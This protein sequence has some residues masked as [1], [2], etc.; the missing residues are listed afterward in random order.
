MNE[1]SA[2]VGLEQLERVEELVSR[3]QKIA[4]MYDEVFEKYDFTIP[5]K[6]LDGPINTYWTYTIKYE[7]DWFELYDKV[8]EAGGDGFYGGLSV[9]Y[10]EPVMS[11]Y[12]YRGECLTAEKTQPKMMQFKANYR[13]LSE[14]EKNIKILDKV[15]KQIGE[16]NE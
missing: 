8:K 6:V 5:Q 15:L 4:K 7:K 14:A 11:S 1:L 3:R 9:P 10:Q 13:N 16:H 12:E 2:A